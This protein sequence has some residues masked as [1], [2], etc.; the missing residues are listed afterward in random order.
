MTNARQMINPWEWQDEFGFAQASEVAG[1]LRWLMCA[2]Q[3]SVDADG[4]PVHPGDI[5]AQ[6]SQAFD[7]LVTVL[8]EAGM[9]LPDVVRLNCYTTDVDGLLE[10]WDSVIGPL[11]AAGC[12]PAMT[13]LG[14]TRLAFPELLVEIEATAAAS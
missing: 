13:L 5:R 2:G 4:K 10:N 7:N 12:H 14:V 9:A 1:T 8:G 11:S 6:V 3:A